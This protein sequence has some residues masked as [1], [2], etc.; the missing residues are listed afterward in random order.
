MNGSS[1]AGVYEAYWP[2][3]VSV[4]RAQLRDVQEAEDAAQETFIKLLQR[5]EPP[6]DVRAW[7][8]AVARTTS[9][10]R[11]R[12]LARERDRVARRVN[13]GHEAERKRTV[14][15]A[16][17]EHVARAML[18][19]AIAKLDA[20]D[21]ELIWERYGRGEPLRVLAARRGVS[22]PTVSRRVAST[23][24]RL[25]RVLSEMGGVGLGEATLPRFLAEFGPEVMGDYERDEGLRLSP[26]MPRAGGNGQPTRRLRVG[27]LASYRNEFVFNRQ[28]FISQM[29]FQAASAGLIV[30]PAVDLVALI[31]TGS[32]RLGPVEAVIRELELHDG[33]VEL[34]DGPALE[35]LDVVIMGNNFMLSRSGVR[36]LLRAV[37]SGTGLFQEG[38]F[39]TND[40]GEKDPALRELLMSSSPIWGYCSGGPGSYDGHGVR[41]PATVVEAHPAMPWLR[42]G[43]A[44]TVTSCGAVFKPAAHATVIAMRDEARQPNTHGG[45]GHFEKSFRAP[46]IIAGEVGRG[47]VLSMHFNQQ[48]LIFPWTQ[49]GTRRFAQTLAWLAQPRLQSHAQEVEA[50]TA[51]WRHE[52]GLIAD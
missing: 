22:V 44:L 7:L 52:R 3:V 47:R 1:D 40:P 29:R 11:V 28:G 21:A 46:A 32:H 39:G 4:C 51:A 33:V 48:G 14:E 26:T 34:D 17:R 6:G 30:D 10:D 16:L 31:D 13:G 45:G 19:E 12:K 50:V 9:V 15:S 23:L 42:R 37:R 18:P 2:L 8:V 20:D 35:T 27:V 43:Q 5:A 38:H 49:Q 24:D 36:A 25:T 41:C